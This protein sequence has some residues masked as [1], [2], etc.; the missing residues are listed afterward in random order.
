M[1]KAA[2]DRLPEQVVFG[3]FTLLAGQ[4]QLLENGEPVKLG[5]RA[6]DILLALVERGGDVLSARELMAR[7][8]PATVVEPN[9]LRVNIAGLR[10]VLGE[11]RGGA[12]YIANVPGRGYCFVAQMSV[13]PAPATGPLARRPQH[14]LPLRLTRMIGRLELMQDLVSELRQHRLLTI[15]GHGGVGKTTLA[16]AL[17]EE[18]L[19]EFPDG[20]RFVDFSTVRDSRHV[21]TT[22]AMAIGL[23]VQSPAPLAQLCAFL[24]DKRLLLVLDNCEHLVDDVARLAVD[25]LRAS[26]LLRL[27]ATSRE[28]LRAPGE[29]VHR[30]GPLAVPDAGEALDAKSAFGYPSVQLFVERARAGLDSFELTDANAGAVGTLCRGLDGLPLVI[31]LAAGC[32]PLYGVRELL[33]RLDER[34][35]VLAQ[36]YRSASARHQ[37]LQALMD[38]SHD[39]MP[40]E[41]RDALHRLSVFAGPFTMDLACGMLVGP[42]CDATAAL[43]LVGRLVAMS[44]LYVNATDEPVRYRM[45]STTRVYALQKL[46]HS[47]H[48]RD[49]YRRHAAL[50]AERLR[51]AG[52]QWRV[53]TRERWLADHAYLVEDALA[54]I[55]RMYACDEELLAI[56]MT[57]AAVP[58]AYQFSMFDDFPRRLARARHAALSLEAAPPEL[59]G[60]LEIVSVFF[61][62]PMQTQ[63]SKDEVLDRVRK[64]SA[65]PGTDAGGLLAAQW[66]AAFSAAA[67][68]D[69]LAFAER[70]VDRLY[71]AGLPFSEFATAQRMR[72]Q[73]LHFMGRHAQA[74]AIA[75]E[76]LSCAPAMPSSHLVSALDER[77]SL[78]IVLARIAWMQGRAAA[79]TSMAAEA[80]SLAATSVSYGACQ[81]LGMAVI[82]IAVWSGETDAAVSA[83][84]LLRDAAHKHGLQYWVS[85]ASLYEAVL[86]DGAGVP[87]PVDAMQADMLSTLRPHALT[88]LQA[89]RIELGTVGWCVPEMLRVDAARVA[90]QPGAAAANK[91]RDLLQRAQTVAHDQGAIA[92]ELRAALS[93]ARLHGP[94]EQDLSR[95]AELATQVA[96]GGVTVDVRE[97]LALLGAAGSVATPP[98]AQ[99][100]RAAGTRAAPR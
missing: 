94:R 2:P 37:T 22:V 41:Q 81:A 21:A 97:A 29:R 14:N 87:S 50:L 55:D 86:L 82:P 80:L 5:G 38:W 68:A 25:L 71:P 100:R 11:Q 77:V 99:P 18:S 74:E 63:E 62:E 24:E 88:A 6:F 73:S 75:L 90:L 58:L 1:D 30:V 17:A 51:G 98:A 76:R 45:L 84:R 46:Q 43:R 8:W 85:W 20:V 57:L 3:P 32:V 39:L 67:Y 28:P 60:Q 96:Q 49:A 64:A 89:G 59:R 26:V 15:V 48:A 9:S 44:L 4:K 13:P 95:L 56:E 16:L 40:P 47:E 33:A 31:E 61:A 79:A 19:A 23:P 78:R 7:A 83:T 65:L 35:K 42:A 10:K 34:F 27:V 92:W 36:G 69:A 70:M 12:R 53:L 52:E 66:M 54:A 91:A 93:L 72:A